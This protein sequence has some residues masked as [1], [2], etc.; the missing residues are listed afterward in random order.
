MFLLPWHGCPD[1]HRMT[2]PRQVIGDAAAG[3][4][5]ADDENSRP[6]VHAANN[7]VLLP[8]ARD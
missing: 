7:N 6:S 1:L 3:D 2:E 5:A 8:H 4:P